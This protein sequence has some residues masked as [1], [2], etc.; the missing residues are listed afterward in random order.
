MQGLH[1]NSFIFTSKLPC[2]ATE[3]LSSFSLYCFIIS[4]TWCVILISFCR[5]FRSLFFPPPV[6]AFSAEAFCSIYVLCFSE[7]VWQGKIFHVGIEQHGT[8]NKFS[9]ASFFFRLSSLLR[10]K[11]RIMFLL[12][13]ERNKKKTESSQ[14]FMHV[15]RK[16]RF[17]FK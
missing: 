16:K 10:H 1:L 13:S 4:F 8:E 3:F 2:C 14:N 12:L 15:K 9:F 6:C 17:S 5:L 11:I 7:W